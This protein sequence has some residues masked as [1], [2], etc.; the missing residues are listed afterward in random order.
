MTVL[1]DVLRLATQRA[2]AMSEADYALDFMQALHEDGAHW[3][4]NARNHHLE[5]SEDGLS[6]ILVAYAA[7]QP[8]H[9]SLRSRSATPATSSPRTRNGPHS[10]TTSRVGFAGSRDATI[11]TTGAMPPR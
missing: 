6:D 7:R 10:T 8:D 5:I 9:P 3:L 4:E 2:A 11:A 1:R